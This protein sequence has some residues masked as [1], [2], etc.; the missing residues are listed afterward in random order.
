MEK[1]LNGE[2]SHQEMNAVEKLMLNSDFDAEAMEGFE[3]AGAEHM[4]H[5]LNILEKRL[6]Q[7]IQP[8]HRSG[9]FWLK[10]AASL[11]VLA[12]AVIFVINLNLN[13]APQQELAG[14]TAKDEAAMPEQS[15]G[16]DDAALSSD[17]MI[18][19][20]EGPGETEQ[21]KAPP[22]PV[23]PKG[24]AGTTRAYEEKTKAEVIAEENEEQLIAEADVVEPI[25]LAE[26]KEEQIDFTAADIEIAAVEIT[27]PELE[28]TATEDLADKAAGVQA[29]ELAKSRSERAEKKMELRSRAAATPET[30]YLPQR[31]II[32]KVTSMED[33]AALPGVNIVLKG[34]TIGTVTDIDGQY[35]ISVPAGMDPTLVISFIGMNSEEVKVADKTEIDV[36]LS[37]DA[38]ALSEVV[39][40]GYGVGRDN[41]STDYIIRAKPEGG[42]AT[43]KKYIQDNLR[44]PSDTSSVKGRVIVEFEVLADGELANFNIIR[45]LGESFDQEAIRVIKEGPKWSPTTRNGIPEN[46]TARVRV[47]F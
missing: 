30:M 25:S 3:G 31:S 35:Q 42:N 47:K 43:F 18:A 44:Y 38:T 1:Y 10:I 8:G 41:N 33:G 17:T 36:Q 2:L 29:T 15:A 4:A 22:P 20:N 12:L 21:K 19:L 37:S 39:V 45:S 26:A 7:R 34:T 32:G 28:D 46:D 9:F 16:K 11:L 6:E 40:T 14:S 5:D 23:E 27:I 13:H 24:V